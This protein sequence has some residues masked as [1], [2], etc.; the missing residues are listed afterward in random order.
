MKEYRQKYLMI[1]QKNLRLSL[2]KILKGIPGD[3]SKR[4]LE[5]SLNE[6]LKPLKEYLEKS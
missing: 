3:I 6:S 1:S 4:S 2:K 5:E